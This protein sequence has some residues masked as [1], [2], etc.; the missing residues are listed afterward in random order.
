VR[1]SSILS[2]AACQIV[3]YNQASPNP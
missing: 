1:K 3:G 2:N